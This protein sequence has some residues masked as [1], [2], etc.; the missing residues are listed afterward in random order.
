MSADDHHEQGLGRLTPHD[1]AIDIVGR[2]LLPSPVASHLGEH[3]MH[4]VGAADKVLL[5]NSLSSLMAASCGS[6]RAAGIRTGRTAR[7]DLLR[8]AHREMR[9]RH[10][11]RAG[12]GPQQ[13]GAWHRAGTVGGL[14]RPTNLWIPL[15]LRGTERAAWPLADNADARIGRAHPPRRRNGA[16]HLAPIAGALGA[17]R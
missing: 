3:S 6:R 13:G 10:L 17:G 7:Q 14:R 9:H 4:F 2:C 11:R 12:A 5:D 1:L 16:G 8:P 15:R